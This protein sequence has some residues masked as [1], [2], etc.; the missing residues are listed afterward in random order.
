VSNVIAPEKRL[1]ILAGLCDGNSETGV[2]R[3][4]MVNRETV[5]RHA[6]M[7]GAAA[8]HLHNSM[9]FDLVSPK[10]EQDEVWSYCGKKQA[11]VTPAE[12]A[13]GL[14]EAYTF[15]SLGM[16]SRYVIAW[17]VG[18]RDQETAM[19]FEADT[20]ARVVLMP[21][22][23]TDGFN[24]YPLAIGTHFGPG[25]DYAALK[26]HYTKGG[27]RDDDHRYEPPRDPFVTKRA[28]FGA[29]DLD[30]STTAHIERH[31][32]TMRHFI[33]RMRRL[34]Y[35]FSKSPEHHK[36]AIALAY[37]Y[38]NL[39]WIP[40]TMRITPAMAIGVT[41]HPWDLPEFL[42]ALMTVQPHAT[43]QKKPLTIPVPATA[44][45]PLPNGRGFIRLVTSGGAPVSPSPATPPGAPAAPVA[46][47]VPVQPSADPSGQLDLLAWRPRPAPPPP[48]GQLDLFNLG[49]SK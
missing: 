16:P 9:A 44:S 20:R 29:P 25:V 18:K 21:A 5:G 39:C 27:R 6:L 43:P 38:Y 11:R 17:R 3:E 46:P 15:V 30:A 31:N 22:I 34:V 49:P 19:A 10:I 24:A 12:H 13:A 2:A 40:R 4:A 42:D 14:G 1:A 48:K 7:F 32:G 37:T 33:G 26:K 41:S 28:V 23:A 45:R 8:Q 47:P 35:A 36:A